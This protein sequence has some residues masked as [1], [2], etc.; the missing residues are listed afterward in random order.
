MKRKNTREVHIGNLKI[1]N[2]NPIA[3]QTMWD[4]PVEDPQQVIRAIYDLAAIGCDII[5]FSVEN[6]EALGP[7]EII[8]EHSPLP[9]V[10]DIHFDYKLAI[11]SLELG[12]SKIRINPG[13]IGAIWKVEEI[14]KSA[15]A[16]DSAI[17]IGING[18]SLPVAYRKRTDRV[19]GMIEI[20]D[21]YVELFDKNSFTNLVVSMKDSDPQVCYEVNKIFADTYDIPLHLGVTEAGPLIPAITK[22]TLA[23]GKL[24]EQGIGDTIR[25]S[26]TGPIKDE[27]IAGKELLKALGSYDGGVKIISCPKCGRAGF[28]TH[29]F[30]EEIQD[31]LEKIKES[32]TV[33]I[34]GCAVNGPGEA[35][36]ADLGI[37]GL[38]NEVVI[39]KQGNISARVSREQ[40]KSKFLQELNSI[41]HEKT[42]N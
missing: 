29:E 9:L 27:V 6:R 36:H 22:S 30:I 13:N 17:R 35:S 41:I 40:A 25:I 28:N 12:I 26:I 42:D 3:I 34:M 31:D 16:H 5:R 23:L 39:F 32:I 38:G 24:I 21:S 37:T 2:G 1:G 4:R 33:A 7:L 8:Q 20:I 15:K 11:S 14:I 18:G 19:T 10:A